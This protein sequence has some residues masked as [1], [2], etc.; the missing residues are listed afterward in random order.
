MIRHLECFQFKYIYLSHLLA[1]LKVNNFDA[2]QYKEDLTIHILIYSYPIQ[3]GTIFGTLLSGLLL[4]KIEG[5]SSVFY[6]FGGIGLVWFV[7][8]VSSVIILPSAFI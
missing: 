2:P 7:L 5:W 6:F 1:A 4:D 8:F 3:M